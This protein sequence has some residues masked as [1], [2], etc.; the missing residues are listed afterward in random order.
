MNNKL[1]LLKHYSDPQIAQANAYNY[2]G[3]NAKLYISTRADKKYMV[4]NPQGQWVH[5]GQMGYADFT[6]HKD[7]MR[8]MAYLKRARA[9][10]GKWKTDKYSP[11]NLSIH[12]LW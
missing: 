4:Q 5:F 11:N 9:I 3:S 2:L 6:R 1:I 10:G 12:I 8:R 7:D